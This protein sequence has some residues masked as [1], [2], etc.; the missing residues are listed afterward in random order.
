MNLEMKFFQIHLVVEQI[1][2][3]I[4]FLEAYPIM[5]LNNQLKIIFEYS[6][7]GVNMSSYSNIVESLREA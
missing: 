6:Y 7:I 4:K 2:N 3:F 1:K 5:L